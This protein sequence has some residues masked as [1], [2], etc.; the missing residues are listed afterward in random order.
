MRASAERLLKNAETFELYQRS[1][2]FKAIDGQQIAND[3]RH[4]A[5]RLLASIENDAESEF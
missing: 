1:G 4:T 2:R 3:L 5:Q